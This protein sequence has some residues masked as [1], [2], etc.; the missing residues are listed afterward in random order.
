MTAL[1]AGSII[2]PRLGVVLFFFLLRLTFISSLICFMG[3]SSVSNSVKTRLIFAPYECL[4][5][6]ILATETVSVA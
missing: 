3:I 1:L 4:F 5:R 2:S 6:I